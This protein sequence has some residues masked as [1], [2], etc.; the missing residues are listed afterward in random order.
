MG[1]RLRM[2]SWW[3][4]EWFLK[5]SLD[6][7]A[8]S[9]INGLGKLLNEYSPLENDEGERNYKLNKKIILKEIILKGELDE[10][11]IEM[12]KNHNKVVKTLIKIMGPDEAIYRGRKAMYH[13]GLLLGQRFKRLL[14]VGEDPKDLINAARIMYTVLGIDFE[15]EEYGKDEMIMVVTH[16]SLANNYNSST[17]KILSAADEGVVQGLNPN[18]HMKFV[19]RITQGHDHCLASIKMNHPLKSSK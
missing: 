19:K 10:K 16:C 11:R 5:K 6:L 18:I 15:V 4:P 3:T 1:L 8:D 12:A 7:L 14:G 17:C 13:E 9:T 2:L